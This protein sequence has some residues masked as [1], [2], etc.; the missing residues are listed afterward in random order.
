MPDA[1]KPK[2]S[3]KRRLV[4]GAGRLLL[5]SAAAIGAFYW[6]QP[7]EFDLVARKPESPL[8]RVDPDAASLFAPGARVAVVVAHPDDPEFYAGGTLTQLGRAGA[9]T[10]LIVATDGDKAYYPFGDHTALSTLRRRE[11][12]TAAGRWGAKETVYLG[13]MDGRLRADEA[14]TRA[15]QRELQR[16]APGYVLYFD[17][18]Y[19]PRLSHADHRRAGQATEAALDRMRYTGWRLRFS[20]LGPNY[21]RDI[22]ADWPAKRDLLKVHHSQFGGAKFARI[23]GMVRDRAADA[24]KRIGA[25]YAESFRA[26]RSP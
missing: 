18:K 11:Q 23:E 7:W 24:G 17:A 9:E 21:F 14:V 19:P 1:T 10:L 6:W 3:R 4:R 5:V 22:T 25:A 26:T 20:T 16:F 8:P 13:F 12:D 2:P 15:I